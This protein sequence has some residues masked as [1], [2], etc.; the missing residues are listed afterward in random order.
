MCCQEKE[1]Q[2]H[3]CSQKATLGDGSQTFCRVLAG[4]LNEQSY[5]IPEPGL[6]LSLC[7]FVSLVAVEPAHLDYHRGHKK[8]TCMNNSFSNC[9][10]QTFHVSDLW[11]IIWISFTIGSYMRILPPMSVLLAHVRDTCIMFWEVNKCNIFMLTTCRQV[12]ELTMCLYCPQ[13]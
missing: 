2:L 5:H 12:S 7:A 13:W 11:K 8:D 10:M 1:R 9:Y 3:I 6:K 4:W